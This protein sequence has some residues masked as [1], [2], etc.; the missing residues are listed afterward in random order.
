MRGAVALVLAGALVMVACSSGPL[1]A[2]KLKRAGVLVFCSD[3]AYPPLEFYPDG[4]TVATG[5]DVD[6]GTEIALRLG[7]VARFD[8]M[9]FGNL[10]GT[11][12]AKKCDAIMSGLND[13]E[14]S[15][16]SADFV[17]YMAVGQSLMVR[18]GNPKRITDLAGLSGTTVSVESGT[19]NADFLAQ[20]SAE[21]VSAGRPAIDIHSFPTDTDAANAVKDGGAYAYFGDSPAVAFYV[22]DDPSSFAFGGRPIDPVPVGV[23][24]RK[25]DTEFR[26]A[27]MR[28]VEAMYA[29]GTMCRILGHWR[30]AG[31]ALSDACPT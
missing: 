24:I 16:A 30:L 8:D 29:D 19:T 5:S 18:T 23:A 13:T 9:P 28:S 15:R 12:A 21:F 4:T 1:T 31:F 27:V 25:T 17:D 11:L 2:A 7:V 22:Y 6:I 20:V 3:V 26:D 14:Q 10:V